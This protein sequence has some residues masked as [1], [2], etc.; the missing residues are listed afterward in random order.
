M[1]DVGVAR[2]C[3]KAK[4]GEA[5]AQLLLGRLY[6]DGPLLTPDW[7]ETGFW[8]E[9]VAQTPPDAQYALGK[10]LLTDDPEVHNR[11][12]GLHWLTKAAENGHDYA[13]YRLG[14]ELLKK[15]KLTRLCLGS[16]PQRRRT[17]PMLN[18]C[19]ANY[20]GRGQLFHRTKSRPSTGWDR[21]RRRV[22]P[23]P[24]FSWSGKTVPL[25]PP[26]SWQ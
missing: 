1:R 19:W 5:L 22:T 23:M 26:P 12:Q 14:K 24:N 4:N 8:F 3:S 11:E 2:L 13:A 7:M 17:T 21:Q 9:Q 15:G 16:K 25:C 18:I 20:S 6:R 10:L